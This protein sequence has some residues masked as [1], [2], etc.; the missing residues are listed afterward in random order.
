MYPRKLIEFG[1][2]SYGITLP[3]EWL[4]SHKLNVDDNIYVK[5]TTNS[6]TLYPQNHSPSLSKTITIDFDSLSL[7]IFNKV[8]ISY[9]LK[10][11]KTINIKGEDVAERFEQIKSYINKLPH[12]EIIS[13]EDNNISLDNTFKFEGVGIDEQ[14]THMS[15]C[16]CSMYDSL[17]V[18][19]I[20]TSFEKIQTLDTSINTIYF[21]ATKILNYSI[22]VEE[23]FKIIMSTTYYSKILS[24]YEKI[25]DNMKRISRYLKQYSQELSD[26]NSHPLTQLFQELKQFHLMISNYSHSQQENNYQSL[27]SINDKKNSILR[28]LE[29]IVTKSSHFYELELVISQLIKD[30]LGLYDEI[31]V[32]TIDK[33]AQ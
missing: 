33:Y 23:D 6:I 18:K 9:Y 26:L 10:N 20:H 22:E 17:C 13:I 15:Q 29:E 12:L 5:T 11:Y 3:I 4:N 14:V 8:L 2:S 27:N 31:L 19:N 24:Q 28:E 16:I 32:I 21:L 1:P 30:I 25:G 7:K